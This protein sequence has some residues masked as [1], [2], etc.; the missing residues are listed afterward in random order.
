L[1]LRLR[2]VVVAL[3]LPLLLPTYVLAADWPQWGQG[4]EHL[5]T[6]DGEG[7]LD[8][9]NVAQLGSEWS[10][11][12]TGVNP[13]AGL[14][15]VAGGSVFTGVD[16]FGSP[17]TTPES[18]KLDA[19]DAESGGALWSAALNGFVRAPAA[20]NGRVFVS[21][22]GRWDSA[23]A[24][25]LYAFDATT[26]AQEW[27]TAFAAPPGLP[28]ACICG[29]SAP[30][31]GDDGVVYVVGGQTLYALDPAS[32]AQLWSA[33]L[34]AQA[35]GGLSDVPPVVSDG[36]VFVSWAT[37]QA[38]GPHSHLTAFDTATHAMLWD[39]V[40]IGGGGIAAV[41]GTVYAAT[42]AL[43]LYA[44]DAQTGAVL[45]NQVTA[46]NSGP[47]AV[48]LGAG[49]AIVSTGTGTVEARDLSDGHL[50]WSTAATG[51]SSGV[52]TP[53][54]IADGVVYL[55][56]QNP[57][58]V[59]AL[60]ESSGSVL[61]S[62]Q[63]AISGGYVSLLSGAV[64]ANG[65]V[66][67]GF[68]RL[69]AYTL[70]HANADLSLTTSKSD[71][72]GGDLVYTLDVHNAGPTMAFNVSV[73]ETIP[74][75]TTL[76]SEQAS[77]GGCQGP[78]PVSCALGQ[79]GSG[80]DAF[81]TVE[82]HATTFGTFTNH[83]VVA[84]PSDSTPGN[85]SSDLSVTQAPPVVGT[86]AL[87]Y[88]SQ[89]D[90]NWEIY[91]WN[92]FGISP[93]NAS[94]HPFDDFAPKWS[95]D[96]TKIVFDATV[97][98]N[99]DIYVMNADGSGLKRLTYT[100]AVDENASW[101]PDGTHIVFDSNR[102][103]GFYEIY[104]MN[105][106]GSGVTRLTDVGS[107]L[108]PA[109]SP[110]G[111][112]IAFTTNR[113]G[114]WEIYSMN[115]DGS[116]PT[117]LT[118]NPADDFYPPSWSPDG[119]K[120]AF[121][122]NRDG[123]W[124]IYTMNTDGSAQTNL[125]HDAA[126]DIE[127]A[128]SPDGSQIAFTSDRVGGQLDVYLLA[129][130]GSAVTAVQPGQPG[131]NRSPA[132]RQIGP[133]APMAVTAAAGN[134]DATVSFTPPL[135]NG[136]SPITSYTVTASPGG[137]S[138]SGS[139]SPITVSGLSNGTSYTFT[140]T[141][142][143]AQATG[144][145][146]APSTA[147][148]PAAPDFSVAM[149]PSTQTVTQ[150]A[151][152][153][154]AVTITRVGGFSDHLN[155]TS[156]GSPPGA[157]ATFSSTGPFTLSVSTSATTPAGTYPLTV[158]VANDAGTLVRTASATLVV[159]ANVV[160]APDFGVAMSPSSQTVTQGA[161]ATFAVTVTETGGFSGHLNISSSGTPPG[162]SATFSSTAQLTVSTTAATPAGTYPLTVRVVD[163]SGT[164]VR[165]AGATLVVT[166]AAPL[167]G[168]GGGGGGGAVVSISI[169]PKSQTIASGGT[170]T[171]TV[172]AI[173]TGGGYLYSGTTT[174]DSVPNCN[175]ALE[176]SSEPGLL[177][178]NGGTLTYTCSI[179]GV[180]TSFTTTIEASGKSANGDAVTASD[181]AQVTVTP[182]RAATPLTPTPTPTPSTGKPTIST[183]G[184][185]TV[186][187]PKPVL[188]TSKHPEV[189]CVVTLTK[190]AVLHETLLDK[191]GHKLAT[192]S[193]TEKA[194]RHTLELALPRKLREAGRYT[195][196]ISADGKTKQVTVVLRL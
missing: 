73:A 42:G 90:G 129:A 161:A 104:R 35:L 80:G 132:W 184:L 178:P 14:P 144:P 22:S 188:L 105:A 108:M 111:S 156:S 1:H 55:V 155:I 83:A 4:P 109:Y 174:D 56:G 168:G 145:A 47:P 25:T 133:G 147:V 123:N 128:W 107:D 122:T 11:G 143:T 192:W 72:Y 160:V 30:A 33:A 152:A 100:A 6:A 79:I 12:F 58:R 48:D 16:D 93:V 131:P 115:A 166:A 153:T 53:P 150:G 75:G 23:P 158:R 78:A 19:F 173:N 119:T 88:A 101:S 164:L 32:G 43:G 121:S 15:A 7:V 21:T 196:D 74:A 59:V 41:G 117:D 31:V 45:W 163:D 127:P 120:I 159:T 183:A 97:A 167:G 142:T 18:H 69:R 112:K 110:D 96:G 154:F 66:Y 17:P 135:A 37:D 191:K 124:E 27:S 99:D 146:S 13:H 171:F 3:A 151:V 116:Q 141:A 81:V 102:D 2:L 118:N 95:P 140:V 170:A 68:D 172:T 84:S 54:T 194:G 89:R 86:R 36:I 29:L 49:L 91:E 38:H 136:G 114:N 169:D 9:S 137:A 126:K 77:D 67:F 94:R 52:D 60:D 62:D 44:V 186:T 65:F 162:A 165:T 10:A 134:G 24:Q 103:Q 40:D 193:Q 138:A 8:A 130:N 51:F 87:A 28:P 61:W 148:T 106:D 125:T 185:T 98:G 182:T 70:P 113:D 71:T 179:S 50:V 149:T 189:V 157:S 76:V 57:T 5:S 20:A 26:G 180:T 92:S 139:G 85:D 181:T 176:T 190:A 82:V 63:P 46:S 34:S 187:T 175:H 177:P 39:D 195:L 64:V